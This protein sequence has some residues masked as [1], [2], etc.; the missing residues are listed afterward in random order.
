MNQRR[1]DI[2]RE[3]PEPDPVSIKQVSVQYPAVSDESKPSLWPELI[4]AI[5]YI[6]VGALGT[7]LLYRRSNRLIVIKAFDRKI[8]P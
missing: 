5:G 8:K 6:S 7:S 3:P 1:V 2:D 4:K